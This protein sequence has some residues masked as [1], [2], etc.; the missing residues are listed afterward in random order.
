MLSIMPQERLYT[1]APFFT[2]CGDTLIHAVLSGR[3]GQALVDD[4]DHPT[5]VALLLD[6]EVA[7]AGNPA[8]LS[9]LVEVYEGDFLAVFVAPPACEQQVLALHAPKTQ[10]FVRFAF[11]RPRLD[12]QHL[13]RL[14]A[15]PEGA[16]LRPL[17]RELLRT[18]RSQAWAEDVM[19]VFPDEASFLCGA[20]GWALCVQGQPVSVCST[21]WSFPGGVEIQIDTHPDYY[22]KGFASCAAAR[23][24][25]DAM[26]RG[27]QPT[28]DAA[29][30]ISLRLAQKL[31][32]Q[33]DHAYVCWALSWPER[34]AVDA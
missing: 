34:K 7:L 17:D 2:G 14:A 32:Y 33:F 1:L 12:P 10:A 3:H 5:G 4:M 20:L 9:R 19:G 18:L 23:F 30:M 24:A 13:E 31:G 22:R 15:P 27:L 26:E 28:W 21:A 8:I 6:R 11:R 16:Q 29:N 25:L